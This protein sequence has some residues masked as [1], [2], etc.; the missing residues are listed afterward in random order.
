MCDKTTQDR[1]E[2]KPKGLIK[3]I[4]H[5]VPTVLRTMSVSPAKL[6]KLIIYRELVRMLKKVIPVVT[7]SGE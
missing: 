3:G 7:G 2:N 6:R 1:G 4:V 5:G